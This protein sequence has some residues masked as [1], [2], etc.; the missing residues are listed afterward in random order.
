[1]LEKDPPAGISAWPRNMDDSSVLDAEVRGADGTPYAGGTFKLEVIVPDRYPFEPP[2]PRF[3]TSIYH[4]NIDSSGRICLDLLNMPPKG[5][6]KPALNISKIL[7]SI[8]LLMSEPNP[9]DPLMAEISSEYI[10]N[11]ATFE[12]KARDCTRLH[13]IQGDLALGSLVG[14]CSSPRLR[15]PPLHSVLSSLRDCMT[16]LLPSLIRMFEARS[17]AGPC[18]PGTL[19]QPILSLVTLWWMVRYHC[20]EHVEEQSNHDCSEERSGDR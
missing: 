18:G 5:A 4:P 13:A 2:K 19:T 9:S 10:N 8:Q 15:A 12:A 11:R 7:L 17:K 14:C 3:V 20:Q 6:W 16:I 1:M